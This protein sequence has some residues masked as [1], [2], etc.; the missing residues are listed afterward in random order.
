MSDAA[1]KSDEYVIPYDVYETVP[2]TVPLAIGAEILDFSVTT[3]VGRAS[4]FPI[5]PDRAS[6]DIKSK[7]LA[8]FKPFFISIFLT[9]SFSFTKVFIE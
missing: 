1:I 9:V 7:L 4:P 2:K 6:L 5:R 3:G 8:F